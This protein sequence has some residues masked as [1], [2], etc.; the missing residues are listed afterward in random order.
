MLNPF[1][2]K[3]NFFAQWVAAGVCDL[4]MAEGKGLESNV[5]QS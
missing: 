3:R 5:L 2:T 4:K 1:E